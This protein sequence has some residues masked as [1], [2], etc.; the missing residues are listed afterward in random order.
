MESKVKN[1]LFNAIQNSS[2]L[3]EIF[4]KPQLMNIVKG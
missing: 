2:I 4:Q 1:Y 3:G